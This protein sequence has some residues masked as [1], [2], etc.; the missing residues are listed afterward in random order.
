MLHIANPARTVID[1]YRY[2]P[3]AGKTEK[4]GILIDEEAALLAFSTYRAS[5]T[6]DANELYR[7]AEVF[8]G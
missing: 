3:L 4:S 2:S 6:Y 8:R 7:L 1:L 5:E